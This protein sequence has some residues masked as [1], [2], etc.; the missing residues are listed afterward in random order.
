RAGH[1]AGG[2]R[3]GDRAPRAR[4][5]ADLSRRAPLGVDRLACLEVEE[6]EPRRQ[7]RELDLLTLPGLTR[8]V[9]SRNRGRPVMVRQ[10]LRGLDRFGRRDLPQLFRVE[11]RRIERE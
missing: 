1:D 6:V 10:L 3:A 5:R 11:D 2:A 7:D 9:D 4:T 8:S